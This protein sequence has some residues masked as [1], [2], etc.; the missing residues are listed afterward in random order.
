MRCI[1]H[2]QVVPPTAHTSIYASADLQFDHV[3]RQIEISILIGLAT[4]VIDINSSRDVRLI[5][6]VPA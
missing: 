3:I 4:D 5:R 6:L 1:A 2:E